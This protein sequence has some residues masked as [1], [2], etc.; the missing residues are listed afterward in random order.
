MDS[1]S[2]AVVG[3]RQW[4][5]W[6]SLGPGRYRLVRLSLAVVWFLATVCIALGFISLMSLYPGTGAV[7]ASQREI[8][9]IGHVYSCVRRGPVSVYGYGYWWECDT[10]ITENDGHVI[11]RVTLG[12]SIVNAHNV[13]HDVELREICSGNNRANCHYGRPVNRIWGIL[14]AILRIV[15][16][17]TI[18]LGIIGAASD[19]LRGVL[20]VPRYYRLLDKL[21]TR[22]R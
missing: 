6:N 5:S 11:D 7:Y 22:N 1:S 15:A 10:R 21:K 20:G 17:A 4:Q 18:S 19:G 13:G 14:Q 3:C 16:I 8:P 2:H 9:V 12:R